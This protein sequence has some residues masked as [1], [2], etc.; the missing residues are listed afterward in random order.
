MK[1][2]TELVHLGRAKGNFQGAVNPPVYQTSTVLFPTLE[3]YHDAERGREH[4]QSGPEGT[5]T[6]P[7]Y[8]IGGT[9]T[10]FILQDALQ[11]LEGGECCLI[12]PSGLSAVT[13]A[14]MSFTKAGDHILVV[15]TVYGPTR[16]FCNKTLKQYGVEVTFFDP[17][18]GAGIEALIQENTALIFL[19][20]PGSLTF[21]VMDIPAITAIAQARGVKTLID[22]SWATPLFYNP[23]SH[24]VDVVI[25]ALTK[26]IGG[27]ADLILGAVIGNKKAATPLMKTYKNLGITASPQECYIALRGLRTLQARMER[28][29]RSAL[30]VA[31]WLQARPEVSRVLYPALPED[32]GHAIWKRDFSG[33]ASLFSVVLKRHYPFEQIASFVNQLRYFGIGCSWGGY[34][35]L[36][37][38]MN[39]SG[40]R[41]ATSWQPEGSALRFYIGLESPEDLVADLEQA[42]VRLSD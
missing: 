26:Y 39:P 3:A 23:L 27:H 35:S 19:E 40:T 36:V 38:D 4:Y 30:E 18:I 33:A 42:F 21:E 29:Q 31:R 1:K 2:G 34:E 15:D 20:S 14:L 8:G 10:T 7:A 28:H 5:R 16:R 24:G 12:T 25:H 32:P 41:S 37:L 22:N 13:L 9:S 11:T 6:D 17:T